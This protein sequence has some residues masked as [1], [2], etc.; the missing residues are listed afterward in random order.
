[1]THVEPGRELRWLGHLFTPG[2]FDGEHR[3]T[4]APLDGGGRTSVTHAESVSG[5]LAPILWRVVGG[6]TGRGFEAMN[7]ALKTRVESGS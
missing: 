2:I 4:L 1:V 5:V 7:A 6:P 3:F